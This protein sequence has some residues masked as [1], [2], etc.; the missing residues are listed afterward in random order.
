MSR[1]LAYTSPARGHLYPAT[2]ILLQMRDRGHE[3]AIRTLA[4]EVPTLTRLGL[5]ARAIDPSLEAITHDDWRARTPTGGL[6]RSVATFAR[7]APYDAADLAEAIETT[8]PDV[9]LV[10]INA[11][12]ALAVAERWGGPWAA[13]C[14][15]PLALSSPDVPPFGLGAAPARGWPGRLRDRSLGPLL[16]RAMG[17]AML[18]ALAAVRADLGLPA[19]RSIDDVFTGPPLLLYLTAE[20]FEYPRARWPQNV[21]L[22]GPCGWEPPAEPPEWFA[23]LDGPVVL[24][25]TSSEFQDDGR[26]VRAAL[27]GLA[28]EPV[29]VVVTVPAADRPSRVPANARVVSFVPHSMVLDRAVCAVTHAGM[30]ATQ[31]ALSRGVP[32]V[33]VPFGRDQPEVARRVEVSDAGVRLPS[34]RLSPQ[35]VREAVRTARAR[36]P[37]AARVA[38]GFAAAGGPAAAAD[39]L[40]QHLM[41]A[42]SQPSGSRQGRDRPLP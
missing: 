7:R 29:T 17:R 25:T 10:D 13:F 12:G 36:A 5:N 30:G 16:R 18:P 41:T 42:S 24:V 14:P 32:V 6:A 31:K 4:T 34:G 11:W 15:Y 8:D 22:V 20:P 38:A 37:G 3:V 27:D 33:A 28:D 40:E 19:Y 39:A 21:R 2:A 23:D 26:L 9:V 35:R 1:V